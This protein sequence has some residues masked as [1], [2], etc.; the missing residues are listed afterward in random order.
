M[1]IKKFDSIK[2]TMS[3]VLNLDVEYRILTHN[4]KKGERIK[5]HYHPEANERVILDNGKVSFFYKD[6]WTEIKPENGSVIV[7]SVP[8]KTVHGLIAK[9]KT[10][11]LVIR[12]REAE[13]VYVDVKS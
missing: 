12:D 1:D 2:E 5:K 13:T 10:Q 11:Y 4:L 3:S 6:K 9:T 8:P 7:V